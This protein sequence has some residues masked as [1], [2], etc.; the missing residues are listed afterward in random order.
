MSSRFRGWMEWAVVFVI[1][2]FSNYLLTALESVYLTSL[3]KT[4]VVFEILLNGAIVS[5]VFSAVLVRLFGRSIEIVQNRL[6]MP[7]REWVWKI[8]TSAAIY[9]LMF[10]LFGFAVYGPIASALD[11]VAYVAEQASIPSSAAGLVFPLEYLRGVIWAC[12]AAVAAF[13]LPFNWKRTALVVGLVLAIPLSFS[14]FLSNAITP[15]L[16]VAHFVELFCENLAFGIACVWVLHLRSRLT[17]KSFAPNVAVRVPDSRRF[18][19]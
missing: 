2:Y 9:L 17:A 6:K 3:L 8:L 14:I 18:S 4:N 19:R 1:L 16:Q 13:S 12:L 10:I 15:S 5:L 7:A 11:K